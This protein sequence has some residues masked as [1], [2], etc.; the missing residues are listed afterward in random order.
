MFENQLVV[1]FFYLDLVRPGATL[2]VVVDNEDFARAL[3]SKS[4]PDGEQFEADVAPNFRFQTFSH[5]FPFFPFLSWCFYNMDV[6][7]RAGRAQ[8]SG[9]SWH[10]S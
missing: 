7:S 9:V 6:N 4:W 10:C 2:L 3:L 1:K 8:E 5:S